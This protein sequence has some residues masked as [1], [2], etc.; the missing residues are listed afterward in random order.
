MKHIFTSWAL[1]LVVLSMGLS[2]AHAQSGWVQQ[3]HPLGDIPL[4]RIQFVN[5]NDGWVVAQDGRLLHTTN[6]GTDWTVQEPEPVDT[7]GILINPSLG[8]SFISPQV[9]WVM[10]TINAVENASGAVLYKT[11]DGGN[12]WSRQDIAS[13]LFG[14]DVQ[15][16]DANT[17]W[18]AVASGEFPDFTSSV[19]RTTDGGS[20]WLPGYEAARKL[21]LIRFLDGLNGWAAVDSIDSTGLVSPVEFLRTTDGGATWSLLH[22]DTSAGAIEDIHVVDANNIWVCGDEEKILKSTNGG[23]SWI[24]ITNTG[25][26]SNNRHKA[27]F[28]ID[29]NRGWVGGADFDNGDGVLYT[30]DGGGSWSVQ[31]S[32]TQ[33]SV[34]SIFF[35]DQNTGW[36]SA[37]YGGL[38][39]TTTGGVLTSVEP[40]DQHAVP[41]R[42][43]LHQNYPN[44]FNP[45]TSISFSLSSRLFVSLKVLD[46]LGREVASLL[47]EELSAGSY[48]RQWDATNIPSGVYFYRLQ[49]GSFTETKKL[50]L[51]R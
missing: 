7:I 47:S 46:L 8:L 51:L 31:R 28:F 16:V 17:G 4:G 49:A 26:T 37:D 38:S 44:P 39:K 15:F 22:R 43:S 5:A 2:Q 6:G 34:F 45:S 42:F 23:V 30:T 1:L 10:G 11:T 48:S 25:Q 27:V 13:K 19:L 18:I 50:I 3:V 41:D 35:I 9:G 20:T 32:E 14:I 12:S 29:A 24:S 21:P 36:L 33:Y 40:G